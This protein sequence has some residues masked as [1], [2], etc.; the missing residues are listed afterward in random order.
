MLSHKLALCIGHDYSI[1]RKSITPYVID[2]DMDILF[3]V[4]KYNMRN[5][6][7]RSRRRGGAIFTKAYCQKQFDKIR[8]AA[9]TNSIDGKE[10]RELQE[11]ADLDDYTHDP[12][13]RGTRRNKLLRKSVATLLDDLQG[14]IDD[15]ENAF[16]NR[17][18]NQAEKNQKKLFAAANKKL[19][20]SRRKT[21]H[22]WSS[23][24]SGVCSRSR[25]YAN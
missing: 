24:V 19:S 17:E 11:Q 22:S 7:T 9:W 4:D 16:T 6:T 14:S 13:G 21:R 1:E 20:A 2:F 18:R 23:F 5:S 3:R 8:E 12:Y 15:A 25:Q 10:L